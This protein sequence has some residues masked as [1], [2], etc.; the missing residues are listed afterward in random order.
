MNK[1]YYLIEKITKRNESS[2]VY[3]ALY[4]GC[5]DTIETKEITIKVILSLIVSLIRNK[6]IKR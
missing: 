2:P 3:G 6:L 1:E 4:S 5:F